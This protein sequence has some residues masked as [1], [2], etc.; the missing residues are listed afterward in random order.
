M[1]SYYIS[2]KKKKDKI[3]DTISCYIIYNIRIV[4]TFYTNVRNDKLL[5]MKNNFSKIG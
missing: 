3:A 5:M 2:V 1:K 4:P